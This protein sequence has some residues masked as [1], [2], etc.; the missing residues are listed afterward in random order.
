MPFVDFFMNLAFFR[1]LFS[2]AAKAAKSARALAPAVL[3]VN[4]R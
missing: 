4:V 2:R 3:L 1:S